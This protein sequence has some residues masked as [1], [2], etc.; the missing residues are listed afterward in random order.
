MLRIRVERAGELGE[1]V[2]VGGGVVV[3]G[4][5]PQAVFHLLQ[6]LAQYRHVRAHRL[7]E[8]DTHV[9]ETAEPDHRDALARSGVP[10]PQ[11]RVQR[12][13][14]AQQGRRGFQRNAV[15]DAQHVVLVDDDRAA[16][17]ALGRLAVASHRVV[18]ADHAA[19][20][21]L[22]YSGATAAALPAGVDETAHADAV[23]HLVLGHV[24]AD[25]GDDA[26]DFV[27]GHDGICGCAPLAAHGVDVGVAD[28]REVDVEGDIVRPD[29]AALDGGFGQRCGRR[30]RGVCGNDGHQQPLC[31]LLAC[32][33]RRD[34]AAYRWIT[35]DN[36]VFS[37]RSGLVGSP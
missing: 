31:R 24:G 30:C 9:A 36:A 28:A 15:G 18:R 33:L 23:A 11:R 25:R 14:G 10:V 2:G 4:A 6:R 8:L 32:E 35:A 20:A 27:A 12:D 13:A 7:G 22:L 5:E 19:L 1:G 3:A 26:G 37:P 17:A 29:V 34:S 16:V 21:V